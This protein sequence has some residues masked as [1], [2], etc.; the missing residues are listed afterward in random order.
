MRVR[1]T[2]EALEAIESIENYSA[3][4]GL[5]VFHETEQKL[6]R[7]AGIHMM[8]PILMPEGS[9]RNVHRLV[10]SARLP[11]KVY[12]VV[13]EGVAHVVAVRHARQR[14]IEGTE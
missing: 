14:P 4:L 5:R 2:R 3:G 8:V 6:K 9:V 13:H 7:F 1:W 10:L 12:Y 11:F